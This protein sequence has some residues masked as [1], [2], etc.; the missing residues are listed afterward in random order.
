M[1]TFDR[2]KPLSEDGL[3]W[4]VTF[5]GR[6]PL[7]EDD[8]WWKKTLDRRLPLTEEDLWLK[9]TFDRR[10]PLMEDTLWWKTTVFCLQSVSLGDTLT[11]ATV[12]PFFLFNSC[13]I[14]YTTG[15]ICY[16][17]VS[18]SPSH[19]VNTWHTCHT[20]MLLVTIT[21]CLTNLLFSINMMYLT[22]TS[23]RW[24]IKFISI[25]NVFC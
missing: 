11:T 23:R 4:K 15:R 17:I 3:L 19:I 14:A 12:R 20:V 18:P 9:T 24:I 13:T 1:T 2:R 6:Q 16:M 7:M 5:D 10:R 25:T 8:L 21:R 22:T